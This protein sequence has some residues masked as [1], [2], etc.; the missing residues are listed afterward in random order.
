MIRSISAIAF[1]V[2]VAQVL[3]RS[4]SGDCHVLGGGGL[5]ASDKAVEEDDTRNDRSKF[6]ACCCRGRILSGQPN[7][8]RSRELERNKSKAKLVKH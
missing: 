4:C 7:H 5:R 2:E 3:L 8:Q 6:G 1:G